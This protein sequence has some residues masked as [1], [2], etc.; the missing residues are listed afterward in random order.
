MILN[1]AAVLCTL[2]GA[3]ALQSSAEGDWISAI[4]E[5]ACECVFEDALGLSFLRYKENYSPCFLLLF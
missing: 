2:N 1:Q 4:P 5:V 3:E